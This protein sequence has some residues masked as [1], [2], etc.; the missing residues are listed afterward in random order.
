MAGCKCCIIMFMP[1]HS[2]RATANGDTPT[3]TCHLADQCWKY[4]HSV[5]HSGVF[6][7]VGLALLKSSQNYG[8]YSDYS[9]IFFCAILLCSFLNSIIN[10]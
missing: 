1:I 9:D 5:S 7:F 10:I 8:I 3:V 6:A 4:D 2:E